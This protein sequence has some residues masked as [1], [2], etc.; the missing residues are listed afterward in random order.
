[1]RARTA[2][3]RRRQRRRRSRRGA[4]AQRRARSGGGGAA[5]GARRKHRRRRRRAAPLCAQGAG[6]RRGDVAQRA[7]A[8]GRGRARAR[9]GAA[10]GG[11]RGRP[12]ARGRAASP[13]FNIARGAAVGARRRRGRGR[14]RAPTQRRR[15]GSRHAVRAGSEGAAALRGRRQGEAALRLRCRSRRRVHAAPPAASK[16]AAFRLPALPL[17]AALR[18]RLV[19]L[20]AH[21]PALPLPLGEARPIVGRRVLRALCA[22]R[23][24]Q[25]RFWGAVVDALFH[26]GGNARRGAAPRA[27]A[28]TQRA[29]RRNRC[30]S[31]KAQRERE[32]KRNRRCPQARPHGALE[33]Q[34][35]HG[36]GGGGQRRGAGPRGQPLCNLQ[37]GERG[38]KHGRKL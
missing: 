9:A 3:G 17:V 31:N 37:R 18:L 16:A 11:R 26:R 7:R 8:V 1:M 14:G 25:P 35:H 34:L 13:A 32:R 22:R 2:E 29:A 21:L 28:P 6:K 4:P 27:A 10:P 23:K 36:E 12:H 30:R 33:A 5:H 24:R 15:G 19:R 38:R 20:R